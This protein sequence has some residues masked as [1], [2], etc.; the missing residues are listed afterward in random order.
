MRQHGEPEIPVAAPSPY[1]DR[2]LRRPGVLGDIQGVLDMPEAGMKVQPGR[3]S[4][5]TATSTLPC[6][7]SATTTSYDHFI[8]TDIAIGGLG[9]HRGAGLVDRHLAVGGLHLKV[10]D[11]LA[12][13]G[14]PVAVLDRGPAVDPVDRDLPGACREFGVPGDPLHGDIADS[15]LVP[16]FAERSRAPQVGSPASPCRREPVGSSIRTST[17]SFPPRKL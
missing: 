7:V 3:H 4:G 13:P 17:D 14:V 8:E 12:D 6:P 9:R 16:A 11:D 1:L 15:S 10:A 5:R 2:L